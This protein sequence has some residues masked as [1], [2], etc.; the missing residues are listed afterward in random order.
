LKRERSAKER[1]RESRDLKVRSA[2]RLFIGTSIFL[3]SEASLKK[4]RRG[5]GRRNERG[6]WLTWKC[7]LE[8]LDDTDRSK[9]EKRKKPNWTREGFWGFSR[10]NSKSRNER[11]GPLFGLRLA[12]EPKS[13]TNDRGRLGAAL[14][15][16]VEGTNAGSS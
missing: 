1:S 5:E 7:A 9:F 10:F 2:G 15:E 8:I 11:G 4:E 14:K 13:P 16:S 12:H 3:G 6:D